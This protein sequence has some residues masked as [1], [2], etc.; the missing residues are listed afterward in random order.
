[1]DIDWFLNS[2]PPKLRPLQ[3]IS[4]KEIESLLRSNL[5]VVSTVYRLEKDGLGPYTLNDGWQRDRHCPRTGR[6]TPG[7]DDGFK[8]AFIGI[9]PEERMRSDWFHHLVKRGNKEFFFG[10]S[11]MKQLFKWFHDHEELMEL[12]RRG[13]KI[14]PYENVE[15][16]DSG[17]QVIFTKKIVK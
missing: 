8:R 14:V 7:S 3:K 17:S 1:M 2:E 4:G 11:S 13:Y 9:E 6:C 15:G 10:F 5:K 12:F 16:F